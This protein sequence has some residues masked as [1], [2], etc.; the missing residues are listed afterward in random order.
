[1][2]TRVLV[3]GGRDYRDYD[4]VSDTLTK[5]QAIHGDIVVCQGGA[6]GAD[7][8]AKQWCEA[9]NVDCVTYPAD[10]SL[11]K[12]AGPIRNAKMWNEFKPNVTVAF[13]GG[14]GTQ[15]MMNIV[16]RCNGR[17]IVIE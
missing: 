3:T 17:L 16:K 5:L 15:G 7:S 10:W 12:A 9:N 14:R 8:L 1:M 4:K 13:P 11:G 2:K 6:R